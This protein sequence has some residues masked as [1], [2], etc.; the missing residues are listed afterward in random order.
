[1]TAAPAFEEPAG[2]KHDYDQ[3]VVALSSVP[4]TLALDGKPAKTAWTRGDVQFIG[5]GLAHQARNSGKA[6][7][8]FVVI[9]IR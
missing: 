6:A 3:I 9:S 4:M 7:A 2:S 8:D 1:M 5:R